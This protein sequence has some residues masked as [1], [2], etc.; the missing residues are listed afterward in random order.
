MALDVPRGTSGRQDA[1]VTCSAVMRYIDASYE[2]LRWR[3]NCSNVHEQLKAVLQLKAC[4]CQSIEGKPQDYESEPRT[5]NPKTMNLEPPSTL[6][7]ETPK[8]AN[9][10]GYPSPRPLMAEV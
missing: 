7:P 4:C 6:N 3:A 1:G 5:L 9:S 2:I 8:P 10:Q